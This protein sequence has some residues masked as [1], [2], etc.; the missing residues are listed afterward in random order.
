MIDLRKWVVP[1]L[2]ALMVLVVGWIIG[3]WGTDSKFSK[4]SKS[5]NDWR[6]SHDR[7]V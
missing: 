7:I 2:V 6:A 1:A 4:S 3:K 5:A